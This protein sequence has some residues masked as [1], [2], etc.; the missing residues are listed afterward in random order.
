MIGRTRPVLERELREICHVPR[1]GI[2][3]TNRR[4]YLAEHT[5]MV[6]LY[7]ND[8]GVYLGLAGHELACLLQRA[9][10]H[11]MEEILT[12]DV[13]GPFKRAAM[14]DVAR[15]QWDVTGS[16]MLDRVF[17]KRDT[18]DGSARHYVSSER[19]DLID[20]IVKLADMIDECSEMGIEISMGN[21]NVKRIFAD[22]LTRVRKWV[23]VVI[24]RSI[25]R[26]DEQRSVQFTGQVIGA[27]L[28]S[29]DGDSRNTHFETL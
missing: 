28:Q 15:K 7:A 24:S 23:E 13:T 11:D 22:S 26:D 17:H 3:R 10:W 2:V 14:D 16:K 8:I 6:T 4:Q 9:L 27:C 5:C 19:C 18:R 21:Q 25:L 1:W 20:A 29:R 12:T